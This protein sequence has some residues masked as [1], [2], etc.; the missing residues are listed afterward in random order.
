MTH[1]A[2]T[3]SSLSYPVVTHDRKG[4]E[5]K[6]IGREGNITHFIHEPHLAREEWMAPA[7][8]RLGG[9]R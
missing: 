7:G 3:E 4:R 6:G 1:G 9:V 2:L 8:A 5:G